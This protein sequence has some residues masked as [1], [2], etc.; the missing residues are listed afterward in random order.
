MWFL[1]LCFR[2]VKLTAKTKKFQRYS[3]IFSNY[4]TQWPTS[5]SAG[6]H[7]RRLEI[8]GFSFMTQYMNGLL[9]GLLFLDTLDTSTW[10]HTWIVMFVS[11]YCPSFQLDLPNLAASAILY[12]C[13]TEYTEKKNKTQRN[14]SQNP[15]WLGLGNFLQCFVLKMPIL[16]SPFWAFSLV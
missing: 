6:C 13:L 8:F 4:R 5:I 9:P 7:F 10:D 12:T 16:S 1:H 15:S 11:P 14:H 2:L 3:F